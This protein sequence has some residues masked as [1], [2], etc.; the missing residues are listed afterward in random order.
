[1]AEEKKKGK[2]LDKVMMGAIIG[3]A[4]GSVIGASVSSKKEVKDAKEEVFEEMKKV[5]NSSRTIFK[6]I[7]GVFRRKEKNLKDS[8]RKIPNEMEEVEK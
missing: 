2:I 6:R 8:A 1:M 3:G 5:G 7:F 4:I